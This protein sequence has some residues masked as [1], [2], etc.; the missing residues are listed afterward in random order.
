MPRKIPKIAVDILKVIA[1]TG[2]VV[3]AATSPYFV[4]NLIKVL[5]K[6]NRRFN[7]GYSKKD[8]EQTMR[9]LKR[10]KI[11]SFKEKDG[12]FF[13]ELTAKGKKKFKE[14][15]I[16]ELKNKTPK[17]WDGLWRIIIFDIPESKKYGRAA[18]R[19]K[20]KELGFYQLQKSVWTLPYECEKEIE[21][22]VELFDIDTFVNF[23]VAKRIK[24]D[25]K[26][27]KYFGLP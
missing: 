24:D 27:K 22:L 1:I 5:S 25:I 11:V 20:M 14:I 16:D 23:I 21:L 9:N 3:I 18:L 6:R 13:I 2:L 12:K 15:K 7:K 17:D 19:G 10:S 8:T 26:L 4:P